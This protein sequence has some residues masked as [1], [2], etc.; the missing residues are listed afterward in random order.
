LYAS[1]VSGVSRLNCA[2]CEHYVVGTTAGTVAH[3]FVDLGRPCVGRR[4]TGVVEDLGEL[5]VEPVGDLVCLVTVV[6]RHGRRREPLS[7]TDTYGRV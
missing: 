3:P 7:S 1:L 5:G 4:G 2:E 6:G